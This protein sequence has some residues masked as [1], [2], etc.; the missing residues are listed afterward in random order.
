VIPYT[1]SIYITS[2]PTCHWE[3]YPHKKWEKF[4]FGEE[5][6]IDTK[7]RTEV[8]VSTATSTSASTPC[9][10]PPPLPP[11]N[12]PKKKKMKRKIKHRG[13]NPGISVPEKIERTL[14]ILFLFLF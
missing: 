14:H 8:A 4:S 7:Q 12:I 10:P 2:H 6:E 3:L 13:T 11:S 1:K 9:Y 5:H